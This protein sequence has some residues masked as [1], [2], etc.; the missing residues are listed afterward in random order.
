MISIIHHII[1]KI[2]KPINGLGKRLF[3]I[4]SQLTP[5]CNVEL[6]VKNNFNKTL[7]IFRDDGFYGPVS[8]PKRTRTERM[9]Y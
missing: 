3:L 6:V 4:V 9:L 2:F 8:G 7:L 5:I 1:N